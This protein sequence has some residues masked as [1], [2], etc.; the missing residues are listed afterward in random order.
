MFKANTGLLHMDLSQC[1]FNGEDT[2]IMNEGLKDNHT[3]L[4]MHMEGNMAQT[5]TLGFIGP[6]LV[7][8]RAITHVHTRM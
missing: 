8:D 4:G 6:D 5:D 1:N 3:I 2:T 7:P